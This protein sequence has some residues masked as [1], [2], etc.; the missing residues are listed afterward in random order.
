MQAILSALIGLSVL[1][2]V[3]GSANALDA[4]SFYEQVD[5]NHY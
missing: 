5:R 4:R 3:A 2:G 1:A